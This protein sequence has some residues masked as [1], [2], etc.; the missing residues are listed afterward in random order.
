MKRTKTAP[1]VCLD[2]EHPECAAKLGQLT[3]Y[4][5]C[6]D[7]PTCANLLAAARTATRRGFLRVRTTRSSSSSASGVRTSASSPR[8]Y[9]PPLGI[10]SWTAKTSEREIVERPTAYGYAHR[11]REPLDV[12]VNLRITKREREAWTAATR[13]A[14][15]ASLSDWLRATCTER[16]SKVRGSSGSGAEPRKSGAAAKRR[17]GSR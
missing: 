13:A 2:C 6:D 10:D 16:A 8:R 15:Y 5:Y 4:G 7:C 1:T 3:E 12:R 11:V 9:H 17:A 14:G